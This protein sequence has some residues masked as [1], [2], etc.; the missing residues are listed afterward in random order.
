MIISLP[1]KPARPS[2]T[3]WT[4]I[5]HPSY[6]LRTSSLLQAWLYRTDL[7]NRFGSDPGRVPAQMGH[8]PVPP[9]GSCTSVNFPDTLMGIYFNGGL[10]EPGV[11]PGTLVSTVECFTAELFQ[12]WTFLASGICCHYDLESLNRP[13]LSLRW[14]VTCSHLEP[15]S[16]VPLASLVTMN[17]GNHV[18]QA[19]DT[20]SSFLNNYY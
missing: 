1:C 19:P 16:T 20:N 2:T 13:H 6:I 10:Q 17:P 15:S 8:R 18:M 9:V 11:K 14:G 3:T 12:P 7:A 5:N 4:L